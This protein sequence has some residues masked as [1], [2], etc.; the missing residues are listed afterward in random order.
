MQIHQDI[1]SIL[2][3]TILPRVVRVHGMSV[4]YPAELVVGEQ[5]GGKNHHRYRDGTTM[6]NVS[7]DGFLMAE[8]FAYD[9]WEFP[10]LGV[11][12]QGLASR[13]VIKDTGMEIPIWSL[14]ESRKGRT[15][16]TVPMP[17]VEAYECRLQGWL[18]GSSETHMQSASIALTGLPNIQLPKR[19]DALPGEALHISEATLRTYVTKQ[20]VLTLRAGD[21][22]FQFTEADVDWRG[23]VPLLYFANLTKDD[24]ASF[25]LDQFPGEGIIDA[26]HKFLSF[27]AGRWIGVP[28]IVCN[29]PTGPNDWLVERAW[30]GKLAP[31]HDHPVS[32]W[33]ATDWE[34]WPGLFEKFWQ[35]Y[36]DASIREHLKNAIHHHGMCASMIERNPVEALG[37]AQ[38]TLEALALWWTD[39]PSGYKFTPRDFWKEFPNAI[40]NAD[41]GGDRKR[42]IDKDQLAKKTEE[43]RKYRNAIEHGRAG[44]IGENIRDVVKCLMYFHNLARLLI[45]AKLD[46]RDTDA[47]GYP[48]GPKFVE[49]RENTP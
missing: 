31:D 26:L 42:T 9:R 8:Y 4:P 2:D 21:W 37:Q 11:G 34:K 36:N 19:R 5:G 27:Q 18:G 29:P 39:K 13:L 32:N 46:D 10:G 49:I 35:L 1:R 24:D 6:F 43:A 47:R 16:H 28:L 44:G 41:L 15:M 23:G 12:D 7:D 25:V 20:A 3:N 22:R 33:T 48:T 30:V 14:R 17:L 40:D 38:A 45:L